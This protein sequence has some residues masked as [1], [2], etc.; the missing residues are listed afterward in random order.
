MGGA[1]PGVTVEACEAARLVRESE[2]VVT[3]TPSHEPIV[4]AEWLH[5]GLHITAM[6]ADT[7]E[8]QELESRVLA[9]ADRL[10]C[11]FRRQCVERGELRHALAMGIIDAA[12]HVSELGAVVSGQA[13]GRTRDDEIT[14]CMLTG[15]GVQDAAIALLALERARAASV[16]TAFPGPGAESL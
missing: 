14:V 12:T 2:L 13:P 3:C 16:G 11:D 9:R 7:A 4:M 1:W 8:K 10:V 6:G 5:P 15:V